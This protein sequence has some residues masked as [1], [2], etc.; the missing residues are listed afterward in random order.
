MDNKGET[1]IVA[2]PITGKETPLAFIMTETELLK[3]NYVNI[4]L[5]Q[6]I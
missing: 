6:V 1:D 5:S 2:L 4:F 3:E